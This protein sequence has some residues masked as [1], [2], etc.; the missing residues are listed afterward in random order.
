[1]KLQ[2]EKAIYGGAGLARV[3]GK[4]IFVPF[5]LPGEVVEAHIIEDK[6]SFANADLD[7]VLESSS[8]RTNPACEYFGLCGGCQYQHASYAQQIEMKLNILRETLQ[9]ARLTSFPEIIPI[10][11]GPFAYRN[12]VRFH[13]QKEPFALC[14][15]KRASHANL[16]VGRCPIAAPLLE[17][18]LKIV[19]QIG[20]RSIREFDEIE[21]FTNESENEL[22]LSLWAGQE[23]KDSP[24]A[25]RDFC[26]TLR[27]ELPVL[28]GAAVFPVKNTET[29]EK[30]LGEW[31]AQAL[32]YRVGGHAYRVS[33][34]SF[35]QVNRFLIDRLVQLVTAEVSGTLAWDLYAGVGL[36]AQVLS[37]RFEKVVAVEASPSSSNDLR[38]NLSGNNDKTVRSGTLE[39]LRQQRGAVPDLIVVDPPRTGLGNSVVSTLTKVRPQTIVYVSCDPA[40]L[41]RDLH[42]LVESGYH[43][44]TMHMVDLFP[45]TFHLESVTVLSLG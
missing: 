25:L 14:Y 36:F 19:T 39:F 29:L 24:S 45:Q 6:R 16:A 2:I 30:K 13:I 10:Y 21:F 41:S 9:R 33:I 38:H 20:S 40:T 17:R 3:D 18:A 26:D 42:A 35:F 15:K 12:R 8:E 31:G 7:A 22:V 1:M 34:G 5:T 43:L 32:T 44:R 11:A 37:Q 23:I 27:Q 28:A 4:A